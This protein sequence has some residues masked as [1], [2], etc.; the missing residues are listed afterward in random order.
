MDF[1]EYKNIQIQGSDWSY[2]SRW[3]DQMESAII[4]WFIPE[5]KNKK[6]SI[7]D[8][9]CGEGR[10]LDV[11]K[12]HGYLNLCGID[13]SEEKLNKASQNGHKVYNSDFHFL[14]EINNQEYDYIFCSHTLEHAYNLKKAIQ[15]FIRV[16]KNKIFIIVPINETEEFVS[17]VNPSH[18]SFI[19]DG[20]EITKI[21]DEL[22]LNYETFYKN[23]MCAEMWII[24]NNLIYEK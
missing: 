21:L 5:I 20:S 13:L 16:C 24:I 7:L 9:G 14:S 11:L 22:N 18:T 3:G 1:E 17:K 6:A 12:K 15:S 10:G 8:I 2:N 4:E 19:T 23:R